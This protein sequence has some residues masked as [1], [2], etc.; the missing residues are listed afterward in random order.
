MTQTHKRTNRC[1]AILTL[2][3]VIT[4]GVFAQAPNVRERVFI[5]VNAHDLLVGETLQYSAFCLSNTTNKPS[6][7]SKYLYVE[8]V[9]E[10][11]VIFQRKH[12]LENG[13]TSGEF[14]V[15]SSTQT[16][17]YYLVAY[18]RW[19]RNFD[20]VAQ[21]PLVFINPYQGHIN[22]AIVA[23]D[24]EV[25]FSTVSGALVTNVN[26]NVVFKVHQGDKLLSRKG[27][28]I[29]EGG[30]Q[31]ADITSDA[32]GIGAFEITP[33][34]ETNYQ[35]LL[36]N[37]EGGF[38]FFDLP[39]STDTG[40]GL[41]ILHSD[42]QIELTP[43]GEVKFGRLYIKH[44]GKV[45]IE[46]DVQS[47]YP[48][49]IKRTELPQD[50]L[51]V[52]FKDAQGISRFVAPLFNTKLGQE[53]SPTTFETRSPIVMEQHL[54]KGS[55]SVSIRKTF[56]S[57]QPQLHSIFS[58][59]G[60]SLPGNLDYNELQRA[61]SFET[62][63]NKPLPEYIS[64]LPEYRYQLLEGTL[65]TE[66]DT[67]SVVNKNV[68][69]SLTGESTLNMSVA[70]TD[71][72]GR[73]LLE[74]Q[75]VNRGKT[76]A[77]HLSMPEFDN[78]YSFELSN[79]FKEEHRLNFFPIVI[80]TTQL[81]EIRER[82]IISQLENAY[83][84]PFIDSSEVENNIP[85]T[86]NSFTAHYEFDDYVRF[87]TLKEHFV[88]YIPV[89]GVREK[90]GVKR[91]V[92]HILDQSFNYEM[93]S[94]VLLDGVPVNPS[95][96]LEFS[97]Y[98]IKSVDVANKR[99]FFGSLIADGVLSF[100]T[101]EGNLGGFDITANHL[102]F[103]LLTPE[104]KTPQ[105]ETDY[106]KDLRIPDSRIQLLWLPDYK[107]N[108]EGTQQIQFNTSD[109]EGDFELVIEGFTEE[110]IPISIIKKF[111]VKEHTNEKG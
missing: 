69:L 73:F 80:D 56:A 49:R 89:A 27:R 83:F 70:R 76:T 101:I 79:N 61:S 71:R 62:I 55:Y 84:T 32:N 42:D 48:I 86:I 3:L 75:T 54:A 20:D 97:P 94:L 14:F 91:F 5:D 13:K 77:A 18:T 9:G 25:E 63:E 53:T 96:L 107:V 52:S 95:D 21:A 87:R 46:R 29:S 37:P 60:L 17:Q 10:G 1:L 109:V 98:R 41:N 106:I 66:R 51:S 24:V 16:G 58:K 104:V 74:Y 38:Q 11:G 39:I 108:Q 102:A 65:K 40:V 111:M 85:T 45:I 35:L 99:Y 105:L 23:A 28:V 12:Q 2:L 47:T 36:E 72:E 22:S 44:Q 64:F 57:Q 78:E 67:V 7:L 50:V 15:P 34:K 68:V 82:S 88:E 19:M 93:E 26:N 30:K 90:R 100:N 8:L 43:V 6:S 110:G 4:M 103:D 81:A 92:V 31:I 33:E 59:E